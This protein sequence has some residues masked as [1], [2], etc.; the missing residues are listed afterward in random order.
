MTPFCILFLLPELLITLSSPLT[1]GR[2]TREEERRATSFAVQLPRGSKTDAEE[3]AA[4][5]GLKFV[6]KVCPWLH[7]EQ[8]YFYR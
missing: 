3:I 5:Y 8:M 7:R 1:H 2:T 4:T 6:G